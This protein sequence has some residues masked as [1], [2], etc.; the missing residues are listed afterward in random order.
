MK[1]GLVVG[2]ACS[3]PCL[4]TR[5]VLQLFLYTFNQNIYF[6]SPTFSLSLDPFS[7]CTFVF[8]AFRSSC[9]V[10]M[11]L[12][13]SFISLLLLWQMCMCGVLLCF[14][15]SITERR[16]WKKGFVYI[17]SLQLIFSR[18]WLC[19]FCFIVAWLVRFVQFF[20]SRE[21]CRGQPL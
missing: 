18:V 8:H 6:N 7:M 5:P 19:F 3:I 2:A 16:L 13:Q 12:W 11:F 10:R 1:Q 20:V 21:K 14:Y 4:G 15:L 9:C 17:Q